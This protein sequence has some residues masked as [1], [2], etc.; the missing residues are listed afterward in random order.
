MKSTIEVSFVQT[1]E[2]GSVKDITREV[3]S[4]TYNRGLYQALYE[5]PGS[6]LLNNIGEEFVE[7]SGLDKV[8]VKV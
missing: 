7:Q 5:I 4:L 2:D 8:E 6:A 1:F 3:K